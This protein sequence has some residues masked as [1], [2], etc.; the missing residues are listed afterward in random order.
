MRSL[1]AIEVQLTEL[2]LKP[3]MKYDRPARMVASSAQAKIER[4]RTIIQNR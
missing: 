3:L 4:L 2:L 1:A